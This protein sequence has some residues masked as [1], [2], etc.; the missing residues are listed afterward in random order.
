[1]IGGLVIWP[2]VIRKHVDKELPFMST[3]AIIIACVKAGGDRQQLHEAIRVHSLAAAK[4]VKEEGAENDL[5]E[6]IGKDGLFVPVHSQLNDFVRPEKFIG[7]APQQV[8]EFVAEHVD[9]ILDNYKNLIQA[10]DE[11][12]SV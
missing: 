12:I 11:G 7:R 6:R 2:L 10:D 3:E 5:L 4:R 8:K 9:H 1:V